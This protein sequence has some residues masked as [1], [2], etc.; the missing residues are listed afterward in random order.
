[1]KRPPKLV[2]SPSSRNYGIACTWLFREPGWRRSRNSTRTLGVMPETAKAAAG[3]PLAEDGPTYK[4]QAT[5][6]KAD[7]ARGSA[8]ASYQDRPNEHGWF[9]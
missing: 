1:M 5:A 2:A 3:V 8:A 4:S 6:T 9:C 7:D